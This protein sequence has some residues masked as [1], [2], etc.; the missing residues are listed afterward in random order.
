MIKPQQD[1]HGHVEPKASR[2]YMPDYGILDAQSGQGLLPW[3]WATERLAR[4]L[5][6]WIATTRPDGQPHMTPVWGVWLDDTFYFSTG[7]RS[8]KARNLAVNPRC[9]VCPEHADDPVILEGVAERVTNP[10]LLRQVADAFS[11]KYQWSMEPTQEGVHDEHG[12]EG[13]VFAIHP[14]VAFAFS[15]DLV[16][17]ATRWIFSED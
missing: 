14:Q 13:P 8:R 5:N 15:D 4:A 10:A 7:R 16:G 9:V 11:Q 3:S 17:S 6:Y 1:T 12:N 2:P